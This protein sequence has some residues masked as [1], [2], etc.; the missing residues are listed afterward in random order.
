MKTKHFKSRHALLMSLTSLMLCVSMLFG[1]TFAWFTDS[2]TSGVNRIVSGNLDVELYH[3]NGTATNEKVGSNT[4]LFQN[5]LGNVMLWEP[6]AMSYETFE[7]RNE[8]T[9]ALK[10][11]LALSTILYNTVTW[12]ANNTAGVAEGSHNLTEVIKIG[13]ID[14]ATAPTRDTV[15][16]A[17][18]QT[19]AQAMSSN[20]VAKTSALEPGTSQ[21][22]SVV[23]YWPQSSNDNNWNLKNSGWS[24]TQPT[25][26]ADY[27]WSHANELA[28]EFGISLY[29]T[30]QASESD[31]FDN[32]YDASADNEGEIWTGT[33]VSSASTAPKTKDELT[34]MGDESL[35]ITSSGDLQSASVPAAAA[36]QVF[37]NFQTNDTD[38]NE[39][40]LNLNVTKLSETTELQAE[41]TT[42]EPAVAAT[43]VNLE[44]DMNAIMKSTTAAGV[45]STTSQN[46]T[47][48]SQYI[49]I[50]YQLASG[51]TNVVATHKGNEMEKLA[52]AD[53]AVSSAYEAAGGYYYNKD[54]GI[55]TIKTKTLSPFALTYEQKA[56]DYTVLN[57][58]GH[59]ICLTNDT[60]EASAKW[61]NGTTLKLTGVTQTTTLTP[62]NAE[63]FTDI[64]G[65]T[66]AVNGRLTASGAGTRILDL[67]G[68]ALYNTDTVLTVTGGSLTI[69]GTGAVYCSYN[70]HNPSRSAINAANCTLVING[71]LIEQQGSEGIGIV[72]SGSDVT[73]N[74][75][76]ISGNDGAILASGGTVTIS[77]GKIYGG[78]N[79]VNRTTPGSSGNHLLTANGTTLEI[80]GGEF[81]YLP[82]QYGN[83]A[84]TVTGSTVTVSENAR[85]H[86]DPG[87]G[88]TGY[89]SSQNES[90]GVWKLIAANAINPTEKFNE[91]LAN[92]GTIQLGADITTTELSKGVSKNITIDLNGHTLTANKDESENNNNDGISMVSGGKLTIC[93]TS[94]GKSG[95]VVSNGANTIFAHDGACIIEGGTIE[96]SIT[97]VKYEI[98]T[99]YRVEEFSETVDHDTLIEINLLNKNQIEQ[100]DKNG[101]VTVQIGET[102]VTIIKV[103]SVKGLL[104]RGGTFTS[105]PTNYLADGYTATQS[106]TTWTV[107]ANS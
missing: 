39:L 33:T 35:E 40:T 15:K 49:T 38:T 102:E 99:V 106:G 73:I 58:D 62:G 13:V 41:T 46:V 103:D 80:N 20:W 43:T 90:T 78:Y 14:G 87:A 104:I 53:A 45:T 75:G 60:A 5:A 29:A 72:A 91:A 98:S 4:T 55:L 63:D 83:G 25:V 96:R 2:V 48:F 57:A 19:I 1:A 3:T 44:I 81:Y 67:N 27:N 28:V 74:G 71:G 9:L 95:K 66:Y 70:S 82:G 77:G 88:L 30:Q 11:Q 101:E 105:D 61:T 68:R 12:A 76:T 93:D 107:T 65:Y 84:F 54:E 69:N 50:N 6:E 79:S 92:G 21:S 64:S 8:G 100:L 16:A 10:Y 26:P 51:L 37:S 94:A 7:V 36:S 89:E 17:A 24:L 31:S 59:V 85:F 52:S 56:L 42:S 22:F 32:Q 18:T 23:L 47:T 97:G 86:F 34:A